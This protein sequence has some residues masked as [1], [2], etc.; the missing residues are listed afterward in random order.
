MIRGQMH[1]VL[2][3]NVVMAEIY[4]GAGEHDPAPISS[5]VHLGNRPPGGLAELVPDLRA[6]SR[7]VGGSSW[8]D[9]FIVPAGAELLTPGDWYQAV[10]AY[11]SAAGLFQERSESFEA[12]DATYVAIRSGVRKVHL[13]VCPAGVR[14]G[15]PVDM[16]AIGR[17]SR[18]GADRAV[19]EMSERVARLKHGPA[20]LEGAP[21]G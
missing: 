19:D 4:R 15:A 18:L 21:M 17:R 2:D 8:A 6:I 10:Q 13:L 14:T 12:G 11:M 1:R 3:F 16:G 9:S 7:S 5:N 20:D